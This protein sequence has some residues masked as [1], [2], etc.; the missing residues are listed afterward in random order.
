M[1]LRQNLKKCHKRISRASNP[2]S[3]VDI[4]SRT[5]AQALHC[6]AAAWRRG[7]A[8]RRSTGGNRSSRAD[9]PPMSR[10]C[11]ANWPQLPRCHAIRATNRP[12]A[13]QRRRSRRLIRRQNRAQNRH[14]IYRLIPYPHIIAALSSNLI[15]IASL[16]DRLQSYWGSLAAWCAWRSAP[17]A[18]RRAHPLPCPW[19]WLGVAQ[20]LPVAV[21]G[22]GGRCSGPGA[23]AGLAAAGAGGR[24]AAPSHTHP[25][26]G[27]D[28]R[29]PHTPPPRN[30]HIGSFPHEVLGGVL[31]QFLWGGW[32]GE[33]VCVIFLD[34]L[35][36]CWGVARCP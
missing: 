21:A 35:V 11:P 8:W 27:A 26:R 28:Q 16:G 33:L 29:A 18:V 12:C 17:L 7:V 5:D 25:P 24:A 10:P 14:S 6:Q 2:T 30:S 22:A 3:T 19:R 36:G 13:A 34:F 1:L 31:D 15:T 32:G 23:G 4:A 9:A 20:A